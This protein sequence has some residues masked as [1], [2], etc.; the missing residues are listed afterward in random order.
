MGGPSARSLKAVNALERAVMRMSRILNDLVEIAKVESGRLDLDRT[1]VP[2][3]DFIVEVVEALRQEAASLSLN[4]HGDVPRNV[5]DV[6]VD[7]RRMLHVFENLVDNAMKFTREGS[8]SLGARAEG[9]EVVFW[10][11]D[12][13]SGIP[14]EDLPHLF[15][16][17]LAR[18]EVGAPR[19]GNRAC[20][21]ERDGSSARRPGLGRQHRRRGEHVLLLLA[22][23]PRLT[24][25]AFP[26][27]CKGRRRG[28]A[29]LA[30]RAAAKPA[31]PPVVSGRLGSCRLFQLGAARDGRRQR[32]HLRRQR[33]CNQ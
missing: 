4:L 27:F 30:D 15:D 7:K 19:L 29:K 10:V 5:P 25:Q 22:R 23:R 13:G 8:I 18:Q 17:D 21:R 32:G 26:I 3:A 20:D 16:R 1:Q 6:W 2:A 11:A 33:G 9:S 31:I 14:P 24:P 12:T 28:P